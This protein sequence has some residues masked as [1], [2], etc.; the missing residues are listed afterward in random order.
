MSPWRTLDSTMTT[1]APLDARRAAMPCFILRRDGICS[2]HGQLFSDRFVCIARRGHPLA[3]KKTLS[4]SA[5]ARAAHALVS[6]CGTEGGYVDDAF[7]RLGLQRKVSM[8]VPHFLAA[9]H[10]VASNDLLLTMAERVADVVAEPLGLVVLSPPRELE[11]PGFTCSL[12]WHERT[13]EDRRGG[14]Y[15]TSSSP[16]RRSVTVQ[17][18]GRARDRR[19]RPVAHDHCRFSLRGPQRSGLPPRCATATR[20]TNAPGVSPRQARRSVPAGER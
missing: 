7:A 5:F 10:I 8:V 14:G 18:W 13:H 9:P 12:L 11:I 19:M 3:K 16:R 15:G 17:G 2:Q 1:G 6:P 20:A 4:M